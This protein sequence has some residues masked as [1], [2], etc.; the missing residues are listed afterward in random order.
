M[1]IRRDWRYILN[2]AWSVRLI[3]LSAVLEA[4]NM[5]LPLFSEQTPRNLFSAMSMSFAVAAAVVR[6]LN[7]PGMD[8]RHSDEP[9]ETERRTQ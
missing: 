3:M 6:V 1:K 4:I 7:Q 8:R 2:R 5:T 9:V